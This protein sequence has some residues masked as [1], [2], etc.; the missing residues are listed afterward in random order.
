MTVI[1]VA[2]RILHMLWLDLSTRLYHLLLYNQLNET[3]KL[4]R[5]VS[6]CFGRIDF[7]EGRRGHNEI[8]CS[9]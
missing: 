1:V 2:K 4:K 5:S 9:L 8:S 6:Q 7:I 3:I